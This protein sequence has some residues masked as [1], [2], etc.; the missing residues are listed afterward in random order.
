[1]K[2]QSKDVTMRFSMMRNIVLVEIKT[3]REQNALIYDKTKYDWIA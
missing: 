2:E 1:M 3:Q